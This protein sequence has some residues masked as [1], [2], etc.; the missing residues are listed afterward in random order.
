MACSIDVVFRSVVCGALFVVTLGG[1]AACSRGPDRTE[2]R[3]QAV[4]VTVASV[5]QK[6]VPIKLRAIGTV[7]PTNSVTV[8]SRIGGTITRI[9]FEEGQDVADGDVL[10]TID[11]RPLEAELRQAEANLARSA[12]EMENARREAARYAELAREGFVARSQYEQIR[13][14]AIALEATVRADRAAVENA[15]VQLGYATI[16]AP[17]AGRTGI[18]PVHEGD[19]VK[20]NDTA[21]VVI[22]RLTPIDVAFALPE[23]ELADVQR[24][25]AQG[26]L[27]VAAV[28]QSGGAPLARG[29]LTFIDNRVDPST[30]TIRLKA[31][32][33]NDP[34]TL[35]PGQFV[36]VVVTLAT[37]PAVVVPTQAVQTGQQGRYVFVVKADSTVESRPVTTGRDVGGETAIASG[38]QAGETVVTEG[39]LR[40]FPGARVE[41]RTATPGA[42]SGHEPAASPRTTPR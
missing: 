4:P 20:A 33:A 14:R 5:Q 39:H 34:L 28:A 25:R 22:N 6:S 3:P 10:F 35:W 8:R 38:I 26:P 23:R 24:Y 30:G 1:A 13:T 29:R 18:V 36:S 32:F 12:A 7:E 11:R 41:V 31:T 40:L 19:L 16:P 17:I 27:D 21:L 37:E 9:H 15:R 42:P 2:R